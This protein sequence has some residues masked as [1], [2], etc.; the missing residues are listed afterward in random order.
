MQSAAGKSAGL[1]AAAARSA[2]KLVNMCCGLFGVQIV[3]GLQNVNTSRIFQTLGAELSEL[4]MLWIAA[5][6]TG[7]L[8]QPLVGYLSDRTRGPLGRRRPYLLA[9][10]I[11]GAAALVIMPNVTSLWAA[12]LMLWLLTGS[13]N[14]AMEPFRALV[15][16][17]VDEE[18]RPAAYATQVAFIGTGAI[19]ASALPWLLSDVFGLA[20]TAPPGILPPSLRAAFAIGAVGLLATVG[21]TVATTAERPLVH[22][23]KESPPPR[24]AWTSSDYTELMRNGLLWLAAAAALAI[25]TGMFGFRPELY[26]IS[27]VLA[28]LGLGQVAA[29]RSARL[30]KAATGLVEIVHDA[31]HMPTVMRRLAVVQ[32]FTWFGLFAMWI[33]A[34]PAIAV[35]DGGAGDP[36]SPAYNA[37]ADWVGILFA[38]YNGVAAVGALFL[39]ALAKRLTRR[40]VHALSLAVGAT[41]LLGLATMP[42][43]TWLLL[44]MFGIGCAWASILSTPYAMVSSAVPAA[45]MGVYMGIHNMFL[46][47]PQLVGAAVLGWIVAHVLGGE[48]GNALVLGAGSLATAALISLTIPDHV[49]TP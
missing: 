9:G 32:F 26:L 21:F 39:P 44:P 25:A 3:W 13:I 12:S 11:V 23:T 2:P 28:L 19:F 42:G 43:G 46:V 37:S 1:G 30:G 31:L 16:D 27:G 35:H 47:L 20:S 38:F 4:P 45:R 24:S 49:S 5:P 40:T 41:G 34:V 17:L 33:Y 48:P 10:A 8:I 29:S 6:L 15:A 14:V 36:G 18:R 22:Q 7:L